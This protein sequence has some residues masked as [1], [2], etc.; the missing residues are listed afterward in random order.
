M[1]RTRIAAAVAA[2]V[3]TVGILVGAAGAV[4]LAGPADSTFSWGPGFHGM[5]YGHPYDQMSDEMREHMGW[6]DGSPA[7]S[8]GAAQ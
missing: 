7:A 8:D 3:L 4:L 5:M 1:I 6:T 2:G